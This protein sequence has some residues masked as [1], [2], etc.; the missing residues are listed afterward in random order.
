MY[1]WA[2]SAQEVPLLL[3]AN[4]QKSC[5]LTHTRR[6]DVCVFRGASFVSSLHYSIPPL[7]PDVLF[8]F[9]LNIKKL[10]P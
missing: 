8:E 3:R 5:A 4:K 6:Y 9:I 1:V 2:S 7:L 10:M